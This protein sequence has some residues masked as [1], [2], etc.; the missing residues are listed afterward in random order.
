M[1]TSVS[2]SIYAVSEPEN[3]RSH[4][5][6]AFRKMARIEAL[7]TSYNDSSQIGQ[8]NI[9]AGNEQ[10]E[11]APEVIN[12]VEMALSVGEESNGAFDITVLPLL[13]L[14]DFKSERPSVPSP[15][16]VENTLASV[17]Y[18]QVLRSDNNLYLPVSGMGIDLGGIAKGYAVDAAF[19]HLHALGYRDFMVEAGGDL[20]VTSGETTRG[21]R[22]VWIRHPR[23]R[24]DFFGHILMDAGAVA[25]SGDYERYF[26]KDGKRYHHIVDPATGYPKEGVMSVTIIAP[27]TALAD[28]YSTAVFVLGPEDGMRLIENKPDIEGLI[29]LDSD[30]EELQWIASSLFEQQL[31]LKQ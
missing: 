30:G 25:S 3:W 14:W 19:E 11:V 16:A 13:R 4:V 31:V 9:A 17:D 24:D 6:A 23:K 5:D 28:A 29:I 12:I 15:E 1:D 8:V 27:S 20:R 21:L 7:T 26:E 22:R 2:I 18:E 10:V